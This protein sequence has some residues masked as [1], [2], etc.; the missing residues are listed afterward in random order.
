MS[1]AGEGARDGAKAQNYA[2]RGD[3]AQVAD[4]KLERLVQAVTAKL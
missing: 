4:Q 2:V 3:S 1:K